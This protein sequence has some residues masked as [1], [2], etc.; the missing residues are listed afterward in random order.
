MF[1]IRVIYFQFSFVLR[2]RGT[3]AFFLGCRRFPV[4]RDNIC[5]CRGGSLFPTEETSCATFCIIYAAFIGVCCARDRECQSVIFLLDFFPLFGLR[6]ILIS[7]LPALM[8]DA[9]VQHRRPRQIYR[10]FLM[11]SH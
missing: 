10:S 1:N 11:F 6:E 3:V 9:S 7:R 2:S 4:N 5:A 8:N